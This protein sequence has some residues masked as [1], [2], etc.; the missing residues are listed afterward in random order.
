MI[1]NFGYEL[2]DSIVT[3]GYRSVQRI[4]SGGKVIAYVLFIGIHVK[5]II[6]KRF[7]K[8][9]QVLLYILPQTTIYYFFSIIR[10]VRVRRHHRRSLCH[11][12]ICELR[13]LG[14]III[15]NAHILLIVI[16]REHFFVLIGDYLMMNIR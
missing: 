7:V 13:I 8:I 9:M 5:G 16:V 6:G 3:G 2:R 1:N 11:A 12:K 4:L 14:F 15:P 10:S